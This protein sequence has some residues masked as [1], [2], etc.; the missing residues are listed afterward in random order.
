MF[1]RNDIRLIPLEHVFCFKIS[2][3]LENIIVLLYLGLNQ[4]LL[5]YHL[6]LVFISNQRNYYLIMLKANV[7][8]S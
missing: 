2:S 1:F 4:Y 7:N 8:I 3:Y 5:R 6:N